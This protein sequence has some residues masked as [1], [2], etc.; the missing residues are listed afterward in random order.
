MRRFTALLFTTIIAIITMGTHAQTD[1]AKD[2]NKKQN[3][4]AGQKSPYLIQHVLNPVDWYPWGD[5]AFTKA[6]KENKLILLS[7]GYSTC[8]W[9]HVMERESFNNQKIAEY[10]NEH[11]VSI[12][13]DREERP[14]VD[15]IY[16]TAYQAMYQG[17]GGWPLN[18]FLTPDLK[19]F[20]GGTYFPPEDK[21]G[22]PGFPRVLET[23]AEAWKDKGADVI[24]S[25]NEIHANMKNVLEQAPAET[26]GIALADLDKAAKVLLSEADTTQGGWGAG[27]KFPQ[28]SHLR[29]L[30]R[31]WQ[32]T[33]DEKAKAHVLLTSD[34]M[35]QGGIHDHLAGGF[36]RYAVDGEWLVPHF[37]KMLYDQAQLLDLYLDLWLITRDSRYRDVAKNL[38]DYVL[39]EMR[40]KGGGFLSAQDA[41]SEGKEG[42]CHCWTLAQAKA[43]LTADELEVT[44][45]WFGLTERGN[46]IDHSDPEPLPNL[47]VLHIADPSWVPDAPEQKQLT[48]ALQKMRQA[49]A[50]RIPA[51]TDD[52]VL[53]DWNGMMISSLARAGRVL[54][55]S[56]YLDAAIKA[57]QFIKEK[58]WHN[59]TL[60]HRWRDGERDNS[61]QSA[62]YLEMMGSSISLY[63]HT[64]D[65]AYLDFA[66]TLAEGAKKLFYDPEHGGFFT[67]TVRKDL[68]L[69]LK[70]D[71]DGATATSSSVGAMHFLTLAEITGRNDLREVVDKTL[72]SATSTIQ[73]SPYALA[74]M[75]CVADQLLESNARLIITKEPGYQELITAANQSY[76][77]RLVVMGNQGKVAT[78][79]QTLQ[80]LD[81]K[82]TAYYCTGQTCKPPVTT[83]QD[84]TKQ[85]TEESQ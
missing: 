71:F 31:Y 38:S 35:M 43:L 25:A 9:C 17:G 1:I 79:T 23:L 53:A 54:G 51:A 32:R 27:P 14:D 30:L 13:V 57:H 67:G 41:Q 75:M 7:I 81:N 39:R 5:E 8:H 3:H 6:K 12:K 21:Q 50:K 63:Q 42:K 24:K 37:E 68:V 40:H 72:L 80:A 46:F 16:M 73:N 2:P 49:R 61:Q 70:D 29:F 62:S 44:V 74:W 84:L 20:A 78:F 82:P 64:L 52:K 36:H 58:L 60:Y 59:G 85:L 56:N 18:M 15:K 45:R 19:P 10:L 11:F 26:G 77:P 48:S 55:E 83:A 22:R 47:N 76:Q 65:P 66:I 33:A 4:L 34:R 28:V 69:R